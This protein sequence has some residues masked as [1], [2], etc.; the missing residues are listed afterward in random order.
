MFIYIYIA[1]LPFVY[2]PLSRVRP[3]ISSY[4]LINA[5]VKLGKSAMES[6]VSDIVYW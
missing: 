4:A 3:Y 6:D 2:V 5:F 1:E